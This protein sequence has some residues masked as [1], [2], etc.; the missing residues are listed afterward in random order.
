MGEAEAILDLVS[1]FHLRCDRSWNVLAVGPSLAKRL[2]SKGPH[3]PLLDLAEVLRPRALDLAGLDRRQGQLLV[4]RLVDAKLDLRGSW[5]ELPS[6]ERA[7]LCSPWVTS[8][9]SWRE[10]GLDF[11]ELG[12][13][14]SLGD[15][16]VTLTAARQQALDLERLVQEV[17]A[18][19]MRLAAIVQ[20]MQ[21]GLLLIE[22]Q[23]RIESANPAATRLL[24]ASERE[25][26][27]VPLSD[28]FTEPPGAQELPGQIEWLVHPGTPA[29]FRA[30]GV[31]YD[32]QTPGGAREV[33]VFRDASDEER[34]LQMQREFITI[35]SHEL[36][37]PVSSIQAPLALAATGAVGEVGPELQELLDIATRNAAR[38]RSLV[39]DVI[40]LERLQA[41][42]LP[43]DLATFRS[44]ELIERLG[45]GLQPLAQQAKLELNIVEHQPHEIRGD[46]GRLLQVLTNL[47][48]NAIKHS[49]VG[50]TVRIS[51]S[52]DR[53]GVHFRVDDEGPGIPE[54]LRSR[55]FDRFY[56]VGPGNR[57]RGGSGLGL[58]IAKLIVDSHEG[59][60]W[61]EA[62]EE[63]PGSSFRL[64]LP[65]S[66]APE[67]GA[68]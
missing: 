9:E 12:P 7:L 42:S 59:R 6:G 21:E 55:I 51:L 64:H 49:P 32:I 56:Q 36:R 63:G 34:L 43:M 44:T 22:P 5:H 37:T 48:S 50:S 58:A 14:D 25:L 4:L 30:R 3:G 67:G 26:M 18:K 15:Y 16:L 65:Q 60:L 23:G 66:S 39:D 10:A 29:E 54:D 40:D 8:E 47:G 41:G 61:V 31:R 52:A 19:E 2:S 13:T 35:V 11:S 68:S 24:G 28:L 46:Q 1:P 33:L 45:E 57:R 20:N 62:R 38:L 53:D 27:G 17:S